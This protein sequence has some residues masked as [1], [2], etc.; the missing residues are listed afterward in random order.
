MKAM[1]QF[2]GLIV[3]V[4]VFAVFGQFVHG[5]VADINTDFLGEQKESIEQRGDSLNEKLDSLRNR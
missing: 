1:F 3:A 4:S 2:V 5:T